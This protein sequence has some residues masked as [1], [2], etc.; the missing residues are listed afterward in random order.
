[1]KRIIQDEKF[2]LISINRAIKEY[3][4]TNDF[5]KLKVS[6]KNIDFQFKDFVNLN[7]SG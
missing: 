4:Q 1:M 3:S 6:F 5:S 7:E 2:I